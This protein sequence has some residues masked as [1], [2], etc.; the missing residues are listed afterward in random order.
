[1]ALAPGTR[2]GPYEI[3]AELGKGGMGEVYRAR[4][5]RVG[6]EVAVKVASEQFSDRFGQEARAIAALNHNNI[7]HFYD[8]GPNYLVMELVEGP[9]LADRIAQGPIPFDEAI[10]IA[11]Q[12]ADALEAA[13]QKGIVHRDL[14]PGNVKIAPEGTVKVLDFGLAKLGGTPVVQSDHSPTITAAPTQAGVILGTAA[15][16]SPEQAKGKPVDKRA[17]IWA[18]GVVLY[19]MLTCKRLF[20]GDTVTETLAAVLEREPK[21]EEVPARWFGT[22]SCQPVPR[23]LPPSIKQL[24][25]LGPPRPFALVAHDRRHSGRQSPRPLPLSCARNLSTGRKRNAGIT[26]SLLLRRVAKPSGSLSRILV[27]RC[28]D[29][30]DVTTRARDRII[31]TSFLGPVYSDPT[32]TGGASGRWQ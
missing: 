12:I 7:C 14:K 1:M 6:R 30:A 2:V 17:D 32:R 31:L 8:V 13:H 9:T 21:W 16:M 19:E 5:P 4:D 23:G 27:G 29:F 22:C 26:Q 11:R 18:F 3:T 28:A 25:T 10:D 24:H 20:Q 15:Y